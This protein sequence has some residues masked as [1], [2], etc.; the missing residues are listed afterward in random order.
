MI[1]VLIVM[2]IFQVYFNSR[3]IVLKKKINLYK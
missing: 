3:L 2:M 1:F